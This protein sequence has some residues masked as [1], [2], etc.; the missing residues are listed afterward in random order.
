MQTKRSE[1]QELKEACS[2]NVIMHLKL[3]SVS[4]Y[5]KRVKCIRLEQKKSTM[6]MTGLF[7]IFGV[8]F[9]FKTVFGTTY[10]ETIN[11]GFGSAVVSQAWPDIFVRQGTD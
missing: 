5:S 6:H 9:S 4:Q 3:L 7:E 1:S 2:K 11:F 8:G 10:I